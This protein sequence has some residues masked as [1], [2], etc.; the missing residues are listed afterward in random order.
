MDRNGAGELSALLEAKAERFALR[1]RASRPDGG[2]DQER[3]A[4]RTLVASAL[5]SL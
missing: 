2:R 3:A 1:S 5:T 4:R